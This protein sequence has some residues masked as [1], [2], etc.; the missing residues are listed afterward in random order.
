MSK[1][2]NRCQKE[3]SDVK[4]KIDVKKENNIQMSGQNKIDEKQK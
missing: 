4:A 2:K 1:H 3:K